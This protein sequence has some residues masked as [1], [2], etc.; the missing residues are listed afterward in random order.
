[1]KRTG[2]IA[3]VIALSLVI[4]AG[5]TPAWAYFTDSHNA[6]GG[7][8]ITVKPD[9]EIKEWYAQATKHVV[10]SNSEDAETPVFVRARVE[11]ALPF[12]AAGEGWTTE[13]DSEGWYYYDGEVAVGAESQELTV[14]FTFPT[15]QSEEQPD[16]SVYGDNYSA[17]VLYEAAPAT[18]DENG[19]PD[20]QWNYDWEANREGGN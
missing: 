1:M 5:I 16:G 19:N 18:Y 17:V 2:I 13:A 9:T 6:D 8:P 14:T 12:T 3:A 20:P 15:V 4:A 11:T 7:L 10:V